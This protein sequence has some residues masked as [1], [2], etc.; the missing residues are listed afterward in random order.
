M[1]RIHIGI[2][3]LVLQLEEIARCIGAKAARIDAMHIDRRFTL[4]DPFGKL[5][6]GATRRSDPEGVTLV[7]PEIRYIPRRTDNRGTNFGLLRLPPA[8]GP[9]GRGVAKRN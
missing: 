8:P 7:Q 3:F 6:T 2:G 1:R 4:D 5:P 9:P